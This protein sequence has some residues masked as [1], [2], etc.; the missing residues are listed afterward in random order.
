MMKL[1]YRQIRVTSIP[2]ACIERLAETLQVGIEEVR[3]YLNQAP[4]LAPG[5]SYR[6]NGVP[7]VNTQDDFA[8]AVRGCSDMTE[9]QKTEWL[10]ED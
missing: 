2:A 9:S 7:E 6:K 5:A 1:E 8:E 3:V 4:R 10:A